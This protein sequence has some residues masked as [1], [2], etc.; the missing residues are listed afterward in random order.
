M[1]GSRIKIQERSSLESTQRK[2]STNRREF[3]HQGPPR[4]SGQEHLS[5]E[6]VRTGWGSSSGSSGEATPWDVPKSSSRCPQVHQRDEARL[7][8]AECLVGGWEIIS[9]KWKNKIKKIKKTKPETKREK[10]ETW[11]FPWIKIKET[12]SFLCLYSCLLC[13]EQLS[14]KMK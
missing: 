12:K 3:S 1:K 4:C 9:R 13:K 11:I 7:F 8:T 6:D 14:C 2:A 10:M 5:F